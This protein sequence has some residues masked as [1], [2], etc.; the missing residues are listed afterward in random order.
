MMA[1]YYIA[2]L[3]RP[4]PRQMRIRYLQSSLKFDSHGSLTP[5]VPNHHHNQFRIV[6]PLYPLNINNRILL[7]NHPLSV[8]PSTFL[9]GLRPPRVH[10]CV[11]TIQVQGAV[12]HRC[13]VQ[14]LQ[15]RPIQLGLGRS[16]HSYSSSSA[17]AAVWPRTI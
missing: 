3:R 13:V 8:S 6:P 16:V 11:Q 15:L 9:L 10:D 12:Y 2:K 5:I 1:N 7:P 17:T 4:P 14:H